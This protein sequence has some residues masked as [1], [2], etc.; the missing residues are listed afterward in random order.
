MSGLNVRGSVIPHEQNQEKPPV[1]TRISEIVHKT[2]LSFWFER[3][4]LVLLLDDYQDLRKD[5]LAKTH[6][7]TQKRRRGEKENQMLERVCNFHPSEERK[8]GEA[9]G[10]K[11][12][13][14][15]EENAKP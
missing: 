2:Y 4:T 5:G 7:P 6:P 1:K 10:H 8:Q 9:G 14:N 15:V 11:K 12:N 3:T 13:S